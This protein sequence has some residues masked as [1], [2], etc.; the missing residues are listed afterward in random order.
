MPYDYR[1]I[2]KKYNIDY[3]YNL[4]TY[5]SFLLR[6]KILLFWVVLF[7]A[8]TEVLGSLD[9]FL[10]KAI[11]DNST[12][13]TAGTLSRIL[14]GEFLVTLALI[15]GLIILGRVVFRW[16]RVH[17]LN[18]FH[19]ILEFDLKQIYFNH[20]VGLS[21]NF[22]TTHKTG[23][24]IS[25]VSRGANAMDRMTEFATTNILPLV[26]QFVIVIVT[27]SYFDSSTV[28]AISGMAVA[29]VAW[30]LYIQKLQKPA[31]IEI[32]RAEDFEKAQLA[33][34]FTNVESIKH[35]GKENYIG[36]RYCSLG[37]ATMNADIKRADYQR[38]LRAG[39]GLIIA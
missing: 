26:L 6:H 7:V 2:S 5:I 31:T 20:L 19:A 29:F 35:F 36:A 23:S 1:R 14:F 38:W 3:S 37:R 25:R 4:K 11:I 13:Y 21:H 27:A 18:R 33:D 24:F 17:A 9:R 10:F 22:H 32:N 34:F 16:L 39:H 15:Y 30:G 12:E 28:I 8:I